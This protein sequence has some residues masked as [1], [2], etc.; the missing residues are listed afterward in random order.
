[1]KK[2]SFAEFGLLSGLT[3]ALFMGIIISSIAFYIYLVRV[4]EKKAYVVDEADIFTEDEETEILQVAQE[5]CDG[6]NIN[7]VVY[8]VNLGGTD[9]ECKLLAESSYFDI[10]GNGRFRD[11]SGIEI[12]IDD[13]PDENG[14]RFFWVVTNGSV[15]YKVRDAWVDSVFL[16]NKS[17]LHSRQYAL[18]TENVI[19]Y[20]YM[21]DYQMKL[22][23][24]VNVLTI[25]VPLFLSVILTAF[26][27]RKRRLDKRPGFIAYKGE[28][29]VKKNK[30]DLID[31]QLFG[32]DDTIDHN[33]Y[34]ASLGGSGS[35]HS[36]GGSHMRSGGGHH[37]GG[38][39]GYGGGHT[40][41]GG[42]RF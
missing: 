42:G 6:K 16:G 29:E 26:M 13:T 25:T 14:Q 3:L 19:R 32:Q 10:V 22:V 30:Q 37:S 21:Y 15:Y 18:A 41:G 39:G 17:Y 31:V 7:V 9:G 20:F 11:N 1:M 35:S 38:G 23:D 28:T 2:S 34:F 36:F 24:N 12:F 5:L 40:G 33:D 8:T 27:S 4:P